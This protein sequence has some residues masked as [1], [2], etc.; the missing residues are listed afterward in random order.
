MDGLF[1]SVGVASFI[2]VMMSEVVKNIL[3]KSLT[4]AG[5]T[6][7]ALFLELLAGVCVG[8]L[9]SL[10]L[11]SP[12]H[13]AVATILIVV[14]TICI[15]QLAYSWIVKPVNTLIEWLRSRVKLNRR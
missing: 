12:N 10:V 11:T 1:L 9:N 5:K 3:P 2:A 13:P 7:I 14:L 15:S 8:L 4:T 6:I